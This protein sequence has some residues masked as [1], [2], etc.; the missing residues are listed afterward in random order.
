MKINDDNDT[1]IMSRLLI[2]TQ[3]PQLNA[4]LKDHQTSSTLNASEPY[5]IAETIIISIVTVLL[6]Y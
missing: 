6:W 3:L 1:S 2:F 4:S 5:D